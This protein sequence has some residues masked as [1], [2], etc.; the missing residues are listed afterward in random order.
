MVVPSWCR[1]GASGSRLGMRR[2]YRGTHASER[3]Y[4][5]ETR[6]FLII[7]WLTMPPP[8]V[9]AS[10]Y[11]LLESLR[12]HLERPGR[13]YRRGWVVPSRGARTRGG[14]HLVLWIFRT[15]IIEENRATLCWALWA[16]EIRL[17]IFGTF[18]IILEFVGR[19]MKIILSVIIIYS[20]Y[21]ADV[22][23]TF[24]QIYSVS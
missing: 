6:G 1:R 17:Y 4:L 11:P 22:P 14:D 8:L 9:A 12:E 24:P 19:R 20:F 15:E 21:L 3:P 10:S 23:Q 16:G 18:T 7:D 13:W 5:G 2:H